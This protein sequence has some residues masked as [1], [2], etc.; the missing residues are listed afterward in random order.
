[1]NRLRQSDVK[2]LYHDLRTK[3]DEKD[4]EGAWRSIF[5]SYFVERNPDGNAKI[6]SPSKVDGFIFEDRMIFALRIL[7]EFKD[8][9]DLQKAYDRARIAIQCIYYMKQ[10]EKKGIDLP[11]VIVGADE[12][13]AFV[14]YAPNFYN[15]IYI[16]YYKK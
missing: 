8:G 7:L 1:M 10:F 14:L 2:A 13:Q 3:S 16:N 11:N 15:T 12:D 5:K 9:T 4:V 6:S